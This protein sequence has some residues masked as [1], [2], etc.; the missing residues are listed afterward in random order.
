MSDTFA[1]LRNGQLTVHVRV[2]WLLCP[3]TF[4]MSMRHSAQALQFC[5]YFIQSSTDYSFKVF[6]VLQRPNKAFYL[7]LYTA[8]APKIIIHCNSRKL[9]SCKCRHGDIW[10]IKE[11]SK[12]EIVYSILCSPNG[13]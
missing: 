1:K 7:L 6:H 10:K 3:D 5:W 8:H 13:K 9:H 2:S 4:S 12:V 11:V